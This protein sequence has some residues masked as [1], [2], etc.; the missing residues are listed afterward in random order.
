[1][2]KETLVEAAKV[3]RRAVDSVDPTIQGI[4]CTSADYCESVVYTSKEWAGKGNPRI[5]RLPNGTY[6]P[7]SGRGISDTM[8]RVAVT[9]TKLDRA[10]VDVLLAE[11]DTI[12]FNRYSKSARYLH[13]HFTLCFVDGLYGAKHW[14]TRLSAY[15]PKSGKAFRDI[16]SKHN[17]FYETIHSLVKNG[18]RMVGANSVVVTQERHSYSRQPW[19]YG[20]ENVWA[21]RVLERMGIPLYFSDI[22]GEANFFE[23]P[24]QEL[25][26]KDEIEKFFEKSVF[27]TAEAADGLAKRGFLD[28]IGCE[29]NDHE[30]A[31]VVAESFDGTAGMCCTKQKDYKRL[32]PTSDKTKTISYNIDKIDGR[33]KIISPAV[34]CYERDGKLTVVY[35]GTPK[36]AHT[37]TEGFA[38]LN[39]SRKRQFVHL[40]SQAGALPVY[41]AGDIEML[42]HGGYIDDGRMLMTFVDLCY[43]PLDT[44]EVYLEKAPK[45]IKAIRANGDLE[46]VD[47]RSVGDNIYELY[48]RIEPMYPLVLVIES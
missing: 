19:N 23:T 6:V 26:S 42:V 20:Y 22:P 5:V 43:D 11:T 33:A 28:K 2:Q 41:Y 3:F 27:L 38:F 37:Y 21:S 15:E 10:G 40:L 36:A 31:H 13:T 47:Y 18:I 8:R 44:L 4:N 24:V 17:G 39:E 46:E 32:T 29:V 1:L 25:L 30:K 45:S 14:I 35:C 16:L 9:K 7:P 34:T 12:P 48:E